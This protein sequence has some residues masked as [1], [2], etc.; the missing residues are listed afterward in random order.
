MENRSGNPLPYDTTDVLKNKEDKTILVL[1]SDYRFKNNSLLKLETFFC[2]NPAESYND[3]Y[4]LDRNKTQNEF[5]LKGSYEF[6]W[7][8]K[9]QKKVEGFLSWG[10]AEFDGIKRTLREGYISY[11]A[12]DKIFGKID[13]FGY[14][15]LTF[16]K[17][18]HWLLSVTEGLSYSLRKN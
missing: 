16:Q 6:D 11:L 17:G 10:V 12:L 3:G 2:A 5:S 4:F 14:G 13:N 18:F 8:K 15:R 9:R 1:N 7:K